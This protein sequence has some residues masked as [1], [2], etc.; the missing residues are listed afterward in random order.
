VLVLDASKNVN[1]EAWKIET[2]LSHFLVDSA[3]SQVTFA[4]AVLNADVPSMGFGTPREALNARLAEFATAR[5]ANA[6]PGEDVY[7]GTI[8]ALQ[9]FGTQQFGDTMVA[10]FGGADDLKQVDVGAVQ[11]AFVERGVRLFGLILGEEAR[12]GFYANVTPGSAKRQEVPFDPDSVELGRLAVETGGF[13]AL[14]N[15]HL[16]QM[17]YHLTEDRLRQLETTFHRFL[18]QIIMLYRIQLS[19]GTPSKPENMSIELSETLKQ[20]VPTARVLFPHQVAVCSSTG[21]R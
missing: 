8:G 13:L 6:K 14:E 17:T 3:P 12:S 16:Q 2:S 10:F 4:L 21:S 20:K 18:S 11:R 1:S 5:P 7:G 9:S 15:T 19:T